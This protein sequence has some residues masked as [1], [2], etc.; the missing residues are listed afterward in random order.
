MRWR[1]ILIYQKYAELWGWKM[2]WAFVTT[3]T[4]TQTDRHT[5]LFLWIV[6]TF[7]RH[8]LLLYWPN[9]IFY[10]L[11]L[12]LTEN[13]FA[14]S[15]LIYIYWLDCSKLPTGSEATGNVR[16]AILLF[17]TNREHHWVTCKLLT[18][19]GRYGWKLYHDI[20]VS[21]RS[22]SIIIDIFYDPFK[23][24]TRRKIYYI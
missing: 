17:P 19:A 15:P 24:R 21:Y 11:N 5:R 10:P 16:S 6:G 12:P 7:H 20:S 3:Y 4:H 13:L 18:R 2:T 22:I 1:G 8:L 23:I 14:L 9:S